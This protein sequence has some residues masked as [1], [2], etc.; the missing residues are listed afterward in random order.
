MHFEG[1]RSYF[2]L[3]LDE[4]KKIIIF[5]SCIIFRKNFLHLVTHTFEFLYSQNFINLPQKNP[6]LKR[7]PTSKIKLPFG[8]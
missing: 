3:K 4:F 6:I 8:L 1:L 5:K 7:N 2:K